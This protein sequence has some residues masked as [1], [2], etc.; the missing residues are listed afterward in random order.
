M[1]KRSAK[2]TQEE[3][4]KQL[5]TTQVSRS[6]AQFMTWSFVALLWSV[7]LLQLF[8]EIRSGRPPQILDL[9]KPLGAGQFRLSL[10]RPFLHRFEE[11]LESVSIAKAFTQPRIQAV[12]TRLGGF[13]N[14]RAVVGRDG[15]LFYRPGIDYVSGQSVVDSAHLAIRAK[16]MVDRQH[17]T[18]PAPDPRPAICRFNA[19]LKQQGIW[20]TVFPAPEKSAL[21]AAQL[22]S[23]VAPVQSFSTLNNAGYAEFIRDLRACGVD[24]FES[25]PDNVLSGETRFLRHDTHWAPDFMDRISA[26]ISQH[27]KKRLTLSG[28]GINYALRELFVSNVGD[29]VEMLH[30]SHDQHLYLPETVRIQQVIDTRTFKLIDFEPT[31]DILI[32]GD[33][34]TN[35]YSQPNL[36][37]GDHAGFA[38]H[39][40]YHLQRP[41]DVL[42]FNG[43][44]AS[45]TRAELSRAENARRLGYKKIVVFEFAIRDLASENWISFP[46]VQAQAPPSTPEPSADTMPGDLE[47]QKSDHPAAPH[48]FAIPGP[49][50]DAGDASAASSLVVVGR[51]VKTSAIPNPASVP[52]KDC[53]SFV[54]ILVERVETGSYSGPDLVAAFQVLKNNVLLPAAEWNVGDRVRLKLIPLNRAERYIRSM[55]RSDDLDDFANEPYYVI[56]GVLL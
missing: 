17:E 33:S 50:N 8:A 16:T 30:L 45:R 15:W 42:A 27:I 1:A 6:V 37:W 31:A 20:L 21:Q 36:G 39:L 25:V 10:S 51:I 46:V 7:P 26:E 2:H 18:A 38:E 22:T 32:L 56:D 12:L 40:A 5:S 35:I 3:S 41:V 54:Q 28:T 11:D 24:V 9:L 34:Y 19:G 23:R 55:Q 4:V 14:D 48:V 44:G 47:H 53:L 13:G 29:L 43:G 52:Y 49:T